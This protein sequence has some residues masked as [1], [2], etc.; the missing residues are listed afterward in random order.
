MKLKNS[1]IL[2]LIISFNFCFFLNALEVLSQERAEPREAKEEEAAT[3]E[4]QAEES[5]K[6]KIIKEKKAELE[7]AEKNIIKLKAKTSYYYG[8]VNSLQNILS[9]MNKEI[10]QMEIS[11]NNSKNEIQR[12]NDLIEKRKAQIEIEKVRLENKREILAQYLKTYNRNSS[13]SALEVLVRKSGFKGYFQELNAYRE[14]SND[15][16]LMIGEIKTQKQKLENQV[17][18]LNNSKRKLES[19]MAFKNNQ[20]LELEQKK[21]SKE[22][23][24]A[25]TQGKE[26]KFQ[27]LLEKEEDLAVKLNTELT[28]IE[29]MGMIIDFDDALKSARYAS[30]LTGVRVPYLLGI[31]KVESNLGANVGRGNYKED[32]HPVQQPIFEEICRNLEYDPEIMPVSKK[33]CYKDEEG[34]CTGW[35]GAMGPAQFMPSTW[36]GYEEKIRELTEKKKADP[37]NLD[38]AILA[39]A[40]KVSK[41]E[42]V[43]SGD[44]ESEHKAANIYLAGGNWENYTWYGDRVLLY[45]DAFELK[46]KEEDL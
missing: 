44:R 12:T 36:K 3:E 7:K 32:M 46:I 33:P 35:G 42:G 30:K 45:A 18:K 4:E 27:E 38:H 9:R 15:I 41:V 29:S 40:V 34:N 11:I 2:F 20:K 6:E 24:L 31:L 25:I 19:L 16:N 37:W 26:E 5:D 23:L 28:L 43:S 8:E 10:E 13:N 14:V 1:K 17:S 21:S 39:M 22:E